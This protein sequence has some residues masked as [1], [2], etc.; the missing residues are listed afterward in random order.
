MVIFFQRKYLLK[1]LGWSRLKNW[2]SA[3]VGP[4]A[5]SFTGKYL[6]P[7][8][9]SSKLHDCGETVSLH[10]RQWEN[11]FVKSKP[12]PKIVEPPKPTIYI[13]AWKFKISEK[14]RTFLLHI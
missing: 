2:V 10:Y 13:Q 8:A 12:A 5:E 14:L 7:R 11:I 1:D 9:G 3:I 4:G 6:I